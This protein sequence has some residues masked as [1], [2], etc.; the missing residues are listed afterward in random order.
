MRP[1]YQRGKRSRD[2]KKTARNIPAEAKKIIK[3]DAARLGTILYT[4]GDYLSKISWG[5]SGY[6]RIQPNQFSPGSVELTTGQQMKCGATLLG[7]TMRHHP[8]KPVTKKGQNLVDELGWVDRPYD[9]Q[10]GKVPQSFLL[11]A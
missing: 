2:T 9:Q 8:K 10:D 5:R 3:L 4:I 6:G 11:D 1:A 7:D